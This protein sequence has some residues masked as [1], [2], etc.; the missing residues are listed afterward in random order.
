M[1]IGYRILILVVI[2]FI[3]LSSCKSEKEEVNVYSG[4]HYQADEE[5]LREF[6]ASTGIEVNLIKGDSDQLINRMLV[7]G[8]NTPADI[9]IT[10]DVGRLTRAVDEGV[11]SPIRDAELLGRVPANLQHPEGYWI[12]LMKRARI[13]VFHRERVSPTE[14]STYESLAD[15]RW[16]GR[17]LVRSSQ[18]HY[19]QSLLASMIAAN[20]SDSAEQ[21][22][23]GL[24]RNMAQSPRGNDRDQVK[25]IAA[26]TG[27]IAIINTYYLGLLLRSSN[28]EER[29]IAS[30]MGLFFPNQQGRGAHIN[31]SGMGLS[32]HAKNK[33]NALKLMR[34][35]L[36]DDSQAYL[37]ASN[38]EYPV[39]TTAP[40]PDLLS[41][42]GQ[43][44]GDTLNISALGSLLPEAMY[45]FDRVGW[46]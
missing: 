27:D 10:A 46:P 2:V 4:R 31:V 34:F 44:K 37:S 8:V 7:E 16:K 3:G 28:E 13:V 35:L 29:R 38:F 21:W 41:D 25:A 17:L 5:L 18:S 11:L 45:I 36:Q 1:R 42:W 20:G 39:V 43:F 12:G 9:F 26:G 40:M 24:V 30:E 23:A 22:A 19:N 6:T 32:A 15:E 14:L 33:E